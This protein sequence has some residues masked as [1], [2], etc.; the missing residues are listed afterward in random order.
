MEYLI[1]LGIILCL[2]CGG[3]FQENC[4]QCVRTDNCP[5]FNNMQRNDQ[6]KWLN[7]FPCQSFD[8]DF[9]ESTT[10]FICCSGEHA[11][12]ILHEPKYLD[13]NIKSDNLSYMRRKTFGYENNNGN[14]FNNMIQSAFLPNQRR[15]AVVNQYPCT[16]SACFNQPGSNNRGITPPQFVQAPRPGRPDGR[17]GSVTRT[18]PQQC[19]AS[20]LPPNPNT[21]CCGVDTFGTN[22]I[23][24]AQTVVAAMSNLPLGNYRRFKRQSDNDKVEIELDNRIAGGTETELNQFPWTILLRASFDFGVNVTKFDCGGSIISSRYILTA[25]HC[26]VTDGATLTNVDIYMSEY[27]KRTFPM[28]CKTSADGQKSCITNVVVQAEK[29]VPHTGFNSKTLKNDIALIRL[30][31]TAPYTEFI[32]PICLPPFDINSQAFFDLPL[33]VAGWGRNV[34]FESNIKQSTVL[35]LVPRNDCLKY[36]P[37]LQASHM[38]AMG[39]TGEDTCKGDS[40][41]PLM[42]IYGGKYYVVGIVSGKRSDVPCGTAVPSLYTN[43]FVYSQW[44]LSNME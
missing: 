4:S 39:K 13:K 42:M 28:D 10:D 40:G 41:G 14:N 19:E 17:L 31:E 8:R 5:H 2:I 6:Q 38:C 11:W 35:N 18:L 36:Y 16:N 12:S 34:Q 26:V 9:Y 21:G 3:A 23:T 20:I 27:D 30:R 25:A 1:S 7:L 22:G 37:Y 24:D 32:R 33:P 15:P 44:I 43:V 29:V